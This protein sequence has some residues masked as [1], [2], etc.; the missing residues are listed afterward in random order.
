MA[1]KPVTQLTVW[2]IGGQGKN[3]VSRIRKMRVVLGLH[4]LPGKNTLWL[5]SRMIRV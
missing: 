1:S 3:R 2:I 4:F 5:Q